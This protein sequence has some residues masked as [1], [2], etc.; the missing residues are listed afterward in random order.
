ML[1][2][3]EI[4]RLCQQTN[5]VYHPP[6]ALSPTRRLFE[7]F[8]ASE[9]Q[10]AHRRL[11]RRLMSDKVTARRN[12]RYALGHIFPGE[13]A[14]TKYQRE[15]W[16]LV[17]FDGLGD[18]RDTMLAWKE[19]NAAAAAEGIDLDTLVPEVAGFLTP[20]MRK[21]LVNKQFDMTLWDTDDV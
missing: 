14:L 15:L 3:T 12:L 7:W 5:D 20:G 19:L 9:C 10:P 4:R 11:M 6:H 17:F 13:Q 8:R 21:L 18:P 16:Y 2:D 1:T